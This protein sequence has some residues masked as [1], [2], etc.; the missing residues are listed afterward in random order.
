MGARCIQVK[1]MY[2]CKT[3][4]Y[5][6]IA[7]LLVSCTPNTM[8]ITTGKIIDLT[9]SYDQETIFWPTEEGFR[10]ESEFAGMTEKG[11]YYT[12]N[13]FCTAEHGGT[14]ID[15]P[16][17]F[18]EGRRSVD[19]IPLEQLIGEAVVIDVSQKCEKDAD[20]RIIAQDLQDW[21]K[22]HGQIP[23]QSI[24]LLRTGFGR[25]W[26]DRLK[27][28]GTAERGE[29]AVAKLHFPGLDHTAAEWLIKNRSIKAVGLDTPSID[30]GQS[31]LFETHR[32]LFEQN[33]PAFENLAHLENL[34]TKDFSVIALPMKIKGGSGA[35]LRIIAITRL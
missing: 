14:H 9:H 3:F 6:L 29:A 11:Y 7:L 8:K 24:I 21:E 10:L 4:T 12:A 30:Y 17:H 35:P 28:M 27:Y 26:P 31:T 25:H 32:V 16:L 2:I 20:Y 34:P 13:K 15:A 1:R 18:A 23:A 22:E 19:Q 33:I 5:L